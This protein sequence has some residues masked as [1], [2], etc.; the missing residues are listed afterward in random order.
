MRTCKKK[1]FFVS[2]MWEGVPQVLSL[3]SSFLIAILL[4][5]VV[6]LYFRARRLDMIQISE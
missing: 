4:T 3:T 2:A 6:Y 5:L 1:I